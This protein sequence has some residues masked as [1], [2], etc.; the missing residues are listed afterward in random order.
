MVKV[1]K[2]L[3]PVEPKFIY[4]IDL[5]EIKARFLRGILKEHRHSLTACEIL[6]GLKKAGLPEE[7]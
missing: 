5:Q 2:V 7:L 4:V 1:I 3:V 6:D